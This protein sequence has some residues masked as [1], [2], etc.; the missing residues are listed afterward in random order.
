MNKFLILLALTAL[1]SCGEKEST[2]I[3]SIEKRLE[4]IDT[5]TPVEHDRLSDTIYL[6]L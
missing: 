5:D 1:I 6:S 2:D 3:E 4:N